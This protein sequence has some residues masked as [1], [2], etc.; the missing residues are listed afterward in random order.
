MKAN[1]ALAS[2]TVSIVQCTGS[3]RGTATME[4][5]SLMKTV[6]RDFRRKQRKR[7]ITDV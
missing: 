1:Y 2:F 7:R 4:A 6:W 5:Y 3:V